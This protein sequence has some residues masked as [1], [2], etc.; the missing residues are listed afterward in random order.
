MSDLPFGIGGP[1][2]TSAGSRSASTSG[3][4]PHSELHGRIRAFYDA[5]SGVWERTWGEHMH[6]GYYDLQTG[7]R[8]DRHDAQVAL[9]DQALRWAEVTQAGSILDAGCGIGGSA[10][11][12]AQRFGAQVEGITLS[13][14]QAQ[15]ANDRA[16]ELD[17]ADSARFQ[18]AD[19]LHTPFEDHSFD[20][21]WSLESGEHYPDKAQ[22][23]REA[24]RILRP[25]GRLIFVTWC[26]R[27]TPPALAPSEQRLLQR[28]YD[29]YHLP[30]VLS[31]ADYSDLAQ[32]FGFQ[33]IRT[34]DWTEH[35]APFW[36][37]VVKSALHPRALF[38]LARSGISTIK[39]ALAMPW[40]MWG[41]RRGVLRFGLL[42]AT[43]RSKLT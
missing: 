25:A 32:E 5:S 39:G 30:Y 13:P 24:R 17:C 29:V 2:K 27:D 43:T 7:A 8:T 37:E 14:V 18:V 22:F 6:H 38:G 34:A 10:I 20:L 41:Y 9:I 1:P 33:A 16:I 36:G 21:I 11:L 19:A 35:V 28:I 15:R 31:L 3:S 12:L 42:T 26:H 23:F 40:M 4:A